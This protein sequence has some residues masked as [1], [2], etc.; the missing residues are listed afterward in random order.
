MPEEKDNLL[1]VIQTLFRWKRQIAL[2]CG[3][4]ILGS[5][6]ISLLLP[7]YFQSVTTF[8]A[9]SSDQAKPAPVGPPLIEREYYGRDEDI[10][11]ILAIAQSG[12]L[13]DYIIKRFHLFGHYDM[14]STNAKAAH[15]CQKD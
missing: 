6:G 10:D 13:V 2:V 12:E 9:T 14:D 15:K 1:G 8:Y 5:I 11:R 7:D 3:L 4:A